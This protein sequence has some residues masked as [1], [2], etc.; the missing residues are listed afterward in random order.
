LSFLRKQESPKALHQIPAFAGMTQKA[1][2][3]DTKAAG[4][5][6]KD[7]GTPACTGMTS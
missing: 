4:M 2:K 1:R 3:D 5:T 7:K 6:Q